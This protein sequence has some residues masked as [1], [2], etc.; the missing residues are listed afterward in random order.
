[1]KK[2]FDTVC[3]SA[4]LGLLK[5][6]KRQYLLFLMVLPVFLVILIFCYFPIYGES[7]PLERAARGGQA[8]PEPVRRISL[9]MK[10]RINGAAL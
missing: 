3:Y 6:A 10:R 9:E 2:L 4:L 5:E 7:Y 8:L 1:M